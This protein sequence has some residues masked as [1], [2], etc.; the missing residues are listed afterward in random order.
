MLTSGGWDT[1]RFANNKKGCKNKCQK[2]QIS[3]IKQNKNMRKQVFSVAEHKSPLAP[4][5]F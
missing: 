2:L 5:R 4:G 1:C 3:S